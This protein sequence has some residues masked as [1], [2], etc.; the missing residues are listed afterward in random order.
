MTYKVGGKMWLFGRHFRTTWP[1]KKLDYKRTGLYAI[2]KV[3]SKNAYKI[4]L[5]NTIWNHNIFHVSLLDR[6]TPPVA[7]QPVSE[8]YPVVVDGSAEEEWAIELLLDSNLRYWKLHYLV[9][10]ASY[11]YLRTSWEPAENQGNA[12][13]LVDE[14][15]GEQAN[16]PQ[17]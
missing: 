3:I 1:S 11:N 8:P 6:Y 16:K 7:G 5:P 10:W 14:F 17:Q 2:C 9:Q 4:D 13:E 12:Q 15:H